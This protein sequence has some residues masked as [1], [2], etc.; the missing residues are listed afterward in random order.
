MRIR[1]IE[2]FYAVM[3]A[4]TVQGAADMLHIT[5][6]AATR[7]LQQAERNLGIRL[8]ERTRGRLVPT[9]EALH[10]FPEVEQVYIRLEHVRRVVTNLAKGPDSQARVL[11]V[12]GLAIECLPRALGQWNREQPGVRVVLKTLHSR[13]I[14]EAIALREAHVG[15]TFEPSPHPAVTSQVIARGRIV[16]VGEQLP[17]GGAA[18]R[19][20]DLAAQPIVDLDP[21]DPLGLLLHAAFRRHDM[22][23]Q[24]KALVHSYHSAIELASQGFGWALVDNHTAA[25]AKRY[26]RLTVAPLEPEIPVSVYALRSRDMPTSAAVSQLVK[27]FSEALTDG[28]A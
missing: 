24:S 25:Y 14:A 22:V 4:G 9:E 17:A 13:Q 20:D 27:C 1:Y 2:I 5:Q 11:C 19:M 26:P 3:Q 18:V 7:L 12:P 23:P 28:G 16:C 8:F 21:A 10:L 6:P 15:F